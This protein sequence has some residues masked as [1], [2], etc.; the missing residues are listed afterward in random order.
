MFVF[1]MPRRLPVILALVCP[2]MFDFICFGNGC[3]MHKVTHPGQPLY[4]VSVIL[5]EYEMSDNEI[6]AGRRLPGILYQMPV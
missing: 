1:P 6:I 3:E 4:H 5:E 2:H